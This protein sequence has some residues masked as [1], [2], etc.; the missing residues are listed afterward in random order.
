[1]NTSPFDEY[2]LP[3]NPFSILLE[4]L[5]FNTGMTY[6]ELEKRTGIDRGNLR[7]MAKGDV[8]PTNETMQTLADAFKI[9]VE[10]FTTAYFQTTGMP[11][12]V[13]QDYLRARYSW[14]TYEDCKEVEALVHEVARRHGVPPVETGLI[15]IEA[16]YKATSRTK[17]TRSKKREESQGSAPEEAAA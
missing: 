10:Y 9:N 14:I 6:Y 16:P 2:I 15:G 7:R 13:L 3:I 8:V 5:F 11:L 4:K 12:P 17:R 1:M